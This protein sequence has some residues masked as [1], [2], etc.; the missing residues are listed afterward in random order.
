MATTS[1]TVRL[2]YDASSDVLW[3]TVA[4]PLPPTIAVPATEATILVA[5]DLSGVVGLV[6]ES[7]T[8]FVRNHYADH[9]RQFGEESARQTAIRGAE[10][11]VPMLLRNMGPAVK[12]Q[13]TNWMAES[14]ASV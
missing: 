4:D 13:V 14:V 11:F 9:I 6:F 10:A 5:E 7:F 8:S 12:D 2:S 1:E 3:V